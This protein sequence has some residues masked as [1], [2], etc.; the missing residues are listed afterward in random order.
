LSCWTNA[1]SGACFTFATAP[2][3][4]ETATRPERYYQIA[5][6]RHPV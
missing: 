1:V 3:G 2:G 4:E 6:D 5:T